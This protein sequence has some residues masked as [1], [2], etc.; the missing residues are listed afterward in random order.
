MTEKKI[1][2]RRCK[3]TIPAELIALYLPE[4]HIGGHFIMQF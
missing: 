4:G 1:V 2:Q 3:E